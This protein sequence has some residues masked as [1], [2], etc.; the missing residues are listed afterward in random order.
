MPG[1]AWDLLSREERMLV[2][3]LRTGPQTRGVFMVLAFRSTCPAHWLPLLWLTSFAR[4][5]RPS[6][7]PTLTLGCWAHTLSVTV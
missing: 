2:V 4:V 1:Q 3:E 6:T 7:S 5:S